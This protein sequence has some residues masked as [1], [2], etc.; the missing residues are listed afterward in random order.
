ML[1]RQECPNCNGNGWL[2]I[3]MRYES[4]EQL[5]CCNNCNGKGYVYEGGTKEF[6][7]NGILK[8]I[9]RLFVNKVLL[10]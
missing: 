5:C 3:K 2:W 6:T 4:F 8:N 1:K 9:Q 7:K 10:S